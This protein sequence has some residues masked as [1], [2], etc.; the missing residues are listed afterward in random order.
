MRFVLSRILFL[1]AFTASLCA[2]GWYA[3]HV[4]DAE[5]TCNYAEQSHRLVGSWAQCVR[6]NTWHSEDN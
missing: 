6:W 1:V 2:L 3:A 4:T 5:Q